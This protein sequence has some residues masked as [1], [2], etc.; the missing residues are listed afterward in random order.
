MEDVHCNI[1]SNINFIKDY[2]SPASPQAKDSVNTKVK[3]SY[4]KRELEKLTSLKKHP[5]PCAST[6]EE[7]E[8]KYGLTKHGKNPHKLRIP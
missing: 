4:L 8:T 5:P 7:F 1:F 2:L 3:K 6:M